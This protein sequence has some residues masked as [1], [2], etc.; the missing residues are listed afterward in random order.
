MNDTSFF[1]VPS[2][3]SRIKIKIVVDY[4]KSWSSII[5]NK[6]NKNIPMGY[7][8]LFCG[9]GKY[10]DG[11]ESVPLQLINYVM[12]NPPICER[13]YFLFNDVNEDSLDNL[14]NCVS[15]IAK[16]NSLVDHIVFSNRMIE[17]NTAQRFHIKDE[18][19]PILSFVDPFGYK[20]LTIDLINKLIQNR[21]SDCIFFFNY[22]R[23]NMALSNNNIF[24]AHLNGIFGSRTQELKQALKG[25]TP[26]QREPKI[27]E[28]LVE[29]LCQ[30]NSNYVIPFKFYS[31]EMIR[32]SHFIVFVTKHPMGCKVMKN[33]MY[34]NSAK[35]ADGVASFEFK[36]SNNFSNEYEQLSIFNRPFDSLCSELLEYNQS[37]SVQE[38]CDKYDK[39][40][41]SRFVGR[42]VKDALIK[43]EADGKISVFN[44]KIK[45]R[46][47]KTCMPDNSVIQV[48]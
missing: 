47:G 34:N 11:S 25:L 42:N 36:D 48:I 8:D 1:D 30:G 37:Y 38:I 6:W 23:I 17:F 5:D 2:E 21:G 39:D 22:N 14:R 33:I 44:R 13:M 10:N 41:K 31:K 4:F 3:Q 45:T 43:L 9:P 26:N 12:N 16:D 27:L 15:I 32:T 19:M 35:D 40:F 18:N 20:G 29:A 24:D 46:K 28:A 7:V